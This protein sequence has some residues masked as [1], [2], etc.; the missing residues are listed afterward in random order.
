MQMEEDAVFQCQVGVE[1]VRSRYATL[2]VP[3]PPESPSIV[4][5]EMLRTQEGRIISLECV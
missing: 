2:T 4:Q 1:P 5:G 3:T